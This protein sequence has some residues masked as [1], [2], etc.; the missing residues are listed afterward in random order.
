MIICYV[1]YEQLGEFGSFAY[2]RKNK[3]LRSRN[4]NY[5]NFNLTIVHHNWLYQSV[6]QQGKRDNLCQKQKNNNAYVKK[7]MKNL[8]EIKV[9]KKQMML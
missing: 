9:K 8:F 6:I 2:K 3:C 5:M 4:D 7:K 1:F